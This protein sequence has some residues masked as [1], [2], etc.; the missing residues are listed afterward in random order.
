MLSVWG[1]VIV[2]VGTPVLLLLVVMGVNRL[3]HRGNKKREEP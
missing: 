3:A 1:D 2:M